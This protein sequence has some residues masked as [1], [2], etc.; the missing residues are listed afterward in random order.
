MFPP[1]PSLIPNSDPVSFEEVTLPTLTP[2]VITNPY[3]RPPLRWLSFSRSNTELNVWQCG[4]YW[5]HVSVQAFMSVP[6]HMRPKPWHAHMHSKMIN[7]PPLI[8][9]SVFSRGS[10]VRVFNSKIVSE[11]KIKK[12]K[13][14]KITSVLCLW[15]A[16]CGTIWGKHANNQWWA[17]LE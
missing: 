12:K 15:A 11:V 2:S 13:H 6:P 17:W 5:G 14:R 9:R 8:V 7:R 1:L 16:L 10:V 4:R 3:H